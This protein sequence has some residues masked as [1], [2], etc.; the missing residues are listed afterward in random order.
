MFQSNTSSLVTPRKALRDVNQG[1]SLSVNG[2]GIKPQQKPI[3][4]APQQELFKKPLSQPPDT[5]Q[6]ASKSNRNQ[7]QLI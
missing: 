4:L 5:L 6:S 2:Q 1:L 3:G 7:V